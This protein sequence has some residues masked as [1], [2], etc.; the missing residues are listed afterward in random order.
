MLKPLGKNVIVQ[1]HLENKIG[2]ITLPDKARKSIA[3]IVVAI[4][5][6]V[7]ELSSLKV[8]DQVICVPLDVQFFIGY[9][10]VDE[11]LGVVEYD[12]IRAVV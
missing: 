6:G 7:S 10:G 3:L 11:S 8:G 2:G 5:P 12:K 1:K 4:G 9:S